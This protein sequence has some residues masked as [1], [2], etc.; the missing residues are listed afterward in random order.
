MPIEIKVQNLSEFLEKKVRVGGDM[1]PLFDFLLERAREV[2]VKPHRDVVKIKFRTKKY[3]YTVKLS[4]DE[5]NKLLDEIKK[6]APDLPI[7]SY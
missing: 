5:A 7:V 3:L 1:V 6:R 4:P 2:R